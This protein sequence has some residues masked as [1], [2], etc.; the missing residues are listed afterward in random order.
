[1]KESLT[2]KNCD[3]IML[4]VEDVPQ[5]KNHTVTILPHGRQIE[6]EAG[7][8]LVTYLV[9]NSIFL[10]SD[11]GGRGVCGKCSVQVSAKHK[12]SE[13]QTA[14]T[15]TVLEDVSIE[16]PPTSMLSSHIIQKAVA[17]L[18]ES[19]LK[20]FKDVP[21]ATP[22]AYGIAID[23]G[24]TTIALYL[25]DM[26]QKGWCSLLYLEESSGTLRG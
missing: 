3:T 5:M 1:M 7:G 10:R 26:R 19:F 25:C 4:Y 17:T 14:C 2:S 22:P 23:L 21:D 11:C 12:Q 13:T 9:E 6:V 24:T 8:N 16:I 18:P 15:F 20:S